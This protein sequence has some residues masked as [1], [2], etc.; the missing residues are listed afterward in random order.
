MSTNALIGI[1]AGIVI[2]GGGVWYVSSNKEVSPVAIEETSE[3]S[4]EAQQNE[5]EGTLADL[6]GRTGSW[7]C[8]VNAAYEGGSSDGTVVMNDGKLRG[9][10]TATMAGITV[11]TSFIGRDGYMYSWTS[12]L[13]QGFKV[14]MNAAAGTAGG[15]GM[16]PSTNVNYSCMP[17]A[18]DE[19]KFVVPSDITFI[20]MNTEASAGVPLPN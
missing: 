18:A 15:Q 8:E 19:S 12:M 6:M 3:E 16:D 11:N 14:E 2:V 7:T 5:G 13:P 1:I 4:Q 20:E 17:W 9:D 10:F